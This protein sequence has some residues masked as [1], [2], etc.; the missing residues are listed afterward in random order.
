[1][2]I[3]DQNQ[4]LLFKTQSGEGARATLS[5]STDAVKIVQASV[6][7][8]VNMIQTNEKQGSMDPAAPIPAGTK[9]NVD[10][11]V[12][13]KGSGTPGTPPEFGDMLKACYLQETTTGTPVP[14]SPGA[15]SAGST[16]TATLGAAASSSAQAYRG[17]PVEISG[18]VTDANGIYLIAD[19]SASKVATLAALAGAAIDNTSDYQ[20][21]ANVLYAPTS[22]ESAVPFCGIKV[23]TDGKVEEIMDARGTVTLTME[24]GGVCRLAFRFTGIYL[25]ES[26]AAVPANPV[27]QS[28]RPPAWANGRFLI[29]RER[30]GV[31]R[32]ELGTNM[33]LVNPGDPNAA[34]GFGSTIGTARDLRGSMDPLDVLVATRDVIADM[35]SGAEKILLAQ[36]GSVAGNR[37]ALTVPAAQYMPPTDRSDQG[38]R[39]RE[40]PF[41]A[42]GPDSGAFLVFF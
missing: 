37:F 11:D 29:H 21:P 33:T 19:Y 12:L 31:N 17:M 15:C 23:F 13:L 5:A 38:L 24:A 25:G 22:D 34:E 9:V 7:R 35:K 16:T 30:A 39:R 2:T 40:I 8:D 1:M 42:N 32:L 4:V 26:D 6:Q 36:I 18:D 14:A 41:K 3:R 10:V 27:F 20:I 28:T